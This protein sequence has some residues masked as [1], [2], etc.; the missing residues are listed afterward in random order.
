MVKAVLLKPLDGKPE[1]DT[2]EMSRGDFDRLAGRRAVRAPGD[3][4]A[5]GDSKKAPP[6]A[7]KKA[8]P[9]ANKSVPSETE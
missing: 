3:P 9:V 5:D 8:P 6:V 4:K 1:G 7:N 2:V